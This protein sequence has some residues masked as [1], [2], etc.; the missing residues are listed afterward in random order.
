MTELTKDHPRNE[1]VQS[2]VVLP[3]TRRSGFLWEQREK[4]KLVKYKPEVIDDL[5]LI[6]LHHDGKISV[7]YTI[8]LGRLPP[9]SQFFYKRLV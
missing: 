8:A 9:F 3:N 5:L 1:G 4:E 2:M 6:C 7:G